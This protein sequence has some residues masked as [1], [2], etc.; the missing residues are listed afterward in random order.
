MS[1]ADFPAYRGRMEYVCLDC[2]ARYPGDDLLYT[3]PARLAQRINLAAATTLRSKL[4]PI[5]TVT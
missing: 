5:S 2:G 3:N 4:N 1:H